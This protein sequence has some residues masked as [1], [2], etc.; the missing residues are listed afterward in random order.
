[1]KL[2]FLYCTLFFIFIAFNVKGQQSKEVNHQSQAWLS[3]NSTVKVVKKWGFMFDL[4]ERRNNFLKDNSF[5]FIR[6]GLNYWLKDNIIL[7]A[8]YGHMW[9]APTKQGWKTFSNENRIYQQ[10][11]M[12]SKISRISVLQRLRNEQRWQQKMVN[13]KPSGDNKYTDRIRYL[14]S[15]TIPVSKNPQHPSLVVADE[16]CVQFGKEVVYNTL[17]QNR[18][19]LGIRQ[20]ITPKL[21]YDFGY[22]Y[23]FQQKYSG[24]RLIY[25][26]RRDLIR[27]IEFEYI[28][29]LR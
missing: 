22:M 3:V 4:H 15:F 17:D 10:V 24:N 12:T 6:A 8:G 26:S 19:F 20:N 11:Q 1:M 9:L 7:T 28:F 23:V 16:L 13:D 5:H 29:P 18:I 27:S 2:S 21:S 25:N 14:L